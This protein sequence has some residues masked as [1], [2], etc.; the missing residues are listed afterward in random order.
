MTAD[1]D[2]LTREALATCK[3][4]TEDT[5]IDCAIRHAIR[6]TLS[7]YAPHELPDPVKE[8]AFKLEE[9][10]HK[11]DATPVGGYTQFIIRRVREF[12]GGAK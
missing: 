3:W 5:L 9:E 6:F 7:R 4:S 10:W 12:D 2:Q 1:I 8:L 11:F